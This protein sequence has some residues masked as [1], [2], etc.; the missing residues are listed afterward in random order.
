MNHSTLSKS[1]KMSIKLHHGAPVAEALASPVRAV[2][3]CFSD[4]WLHVTTH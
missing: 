3:T 1:G 4:Y 2:T